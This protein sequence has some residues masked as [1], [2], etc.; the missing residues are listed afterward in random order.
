MPNSGDENRIILVLLEDKNR[1][2]KM[3]S[4]YSILEHF[5]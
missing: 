3:S 1:M 2:M 4:K 5:G